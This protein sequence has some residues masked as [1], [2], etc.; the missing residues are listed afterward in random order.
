MAGQHSPLAEN[1]AN[2][3]LGDAAVPEPASEADTPFVKP[4]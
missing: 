3:R 4:A 1:T 2:L